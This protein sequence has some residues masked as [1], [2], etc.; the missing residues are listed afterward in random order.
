MA[1]K[2]ATLKAL[3]AKA[4]LGQ[5]LKQNGGTKEDLQ[6]MVEELN[7]CKTLEDL[8]EVYEYF[9]RDADLAKM[10]VLELL[11]KYGNLPAVS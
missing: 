2:L 8:F 4:D 5:Y 1:I 10:E 6:E 7:R 9:G 11:M 3:V